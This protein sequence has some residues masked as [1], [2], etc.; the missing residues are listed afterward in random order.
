M[1][2]QK[3]TED[4]VVPLYCFDHVS[5]C[6]SAG[7][8]LGAGPDLREVSPG[9]LQPRPG[10]SLLHRDITLR[11]NPGPAAFHVDDRQTGMCCLSCRIVCVCVPVRMCD[12]DL[13]LKPTGCGESCYS[14]I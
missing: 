11:C 12:N 13:D 5:V 8:L 4:E 10:K 9:L 1:S 6:V 14:T 2:S 7:C 3:C